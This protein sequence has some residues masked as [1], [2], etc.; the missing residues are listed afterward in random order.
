MKNTFTF[1][2]LISAVAIA[3]PLIGCS[4]D[5]KSSRDSAP[6]YGGGGGGGNGTSTGTGTG[7]GT[8]NGGDPGSA[9]SLDLT[10]GIQEDA[11]QADLEDMAGRIKKF[12]QGVWDGTEGQAYLGEQTLVNNSS[13]GNVLIKSIKGPIGNPPAACAMGGSGYWQI[14]MSTAAIPMQCFTHELGHGWVGPFQSE[15]YNC[16]SAANDICIQGACTTGGEGVGL[17]CDPSNCLENQQCWNQMQQTHGWEHPGPGGAVPTC[18]V[19]IQ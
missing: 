1:I 9:V 15:E 19:T 11:S 3:L 6:A 5:H 18:N 2:I 16:V 4:K 8:G 10:W 14:R 13:E 7:S 12:N 17:W